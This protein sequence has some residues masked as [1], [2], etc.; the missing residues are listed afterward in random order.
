MFDKILV[1]ITASESNL[2]VFD[3]GLK[4]AKATGAHLGVIHVT[5]PDE[6]ADDK[7]ACFNALEPFLSGEDE[8]E[9]YC[10][11]G[12]FETSEPDLFGAYASK[13]SAEGVSMECIHCFGDPEQAIND[14][15]LTWKPSLIVLGR[16]QRSEI[17]EFFLGSVSNYTLHHAQCSIYVV[18]ESTSVISRRAS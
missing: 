12:H 1:A 9:P 15:A 16:R 3:H 10:Y 13:A 11:V 6:T 17:A 7:P 4:L 2:Y 14:F 8:S 5:D 18:N